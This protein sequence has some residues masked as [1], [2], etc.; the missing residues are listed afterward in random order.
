MK[1][2]NKSESYDFDIIYLKSLINGC[3]DVDKL[4]TLN[5]RLNLL[6]E[7]KRVFENYN[8]VEEKEE[9]CPHCDQVLLWEPKSR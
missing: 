8:P 7:Q 4:K 9:R 2:K 3:K 1:N 5:S 6:V